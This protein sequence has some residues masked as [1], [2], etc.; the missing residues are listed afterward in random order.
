VPEETS[1]VFVQPVSL[2]AH[3]Y[4][5][6][7]SA[8]RSTKCFPPFGL[9]D[10]SFE[11]PSYLT[12]PCYMTCLYYA[13][14]L[15]HPNYKLFGEAYRNYVAPH[16]AICSNLLLFQLYYNFEF[17]SYLNER[18]PNRIFRKT[19]KVAC[20]KLVWLEERAVITVKLKGSAVKEIVK[21][22]TLRSGRNNL[23][24]AEDQQ[25]EIPATLRSMHKAMITL[26]KKFKTLFCRCCFMHRD[27]ICTFLTN[28]INK[29]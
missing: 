6:L 21:D 7:P 26:M 23:C 22:I 2:K 18:V 16:S 11:A 10:Q 15:D 20:T 19:G 14:R 5:F 4:I 29:K 17:F 28:K 9:S 12:L 25:A 27:N 1:S 24:A 8:L 3:F 13:P